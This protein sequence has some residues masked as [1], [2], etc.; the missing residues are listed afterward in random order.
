[1]DTR[2]LS[3]KVAAVTGAAS[4][5]GR[6]TALAMAERG[7]DLAICDVD[8]AGL[9]ETA[10]AMASR[11][12]LCEL[13]HHIARCGPGR[14]DLGLTCRSPSY[15]RTPRCLRVFDPT[16]MAGSRSPRLG[17][18]LRPNRSHSVR[19]PESR[20]HDSAR[21]G[22]GPVLETPRE[23]PRHQ[24]PG[25]HRR[26]LR[27]PEARRCLS[28][29]LFRGF[30]HPTGTSCRR[31][32]DALASVV[33]PEPHRGDQFRGRRLFVLPGQD[34]RRALGPSTRSRRRCHLLRLE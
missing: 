4:G 8:E 16:G 13:R 22:S 21:K 15:I 17:I 30:L 23:L 14:I 25:L 12:H 26:R 3:G 10:A 32:D 5:I 34:S 18:P 19:L 27:G 24:F 6:A 11:R 1:M 28:H 2:N 9:K 29:G 31:G 33:R 20:S 7:A